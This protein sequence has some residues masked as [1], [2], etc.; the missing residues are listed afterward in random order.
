[1]ERHRVYT[2]IQRHA[3][4]TQHKGHIHM[5]H[6][7]HLCPSHDPSLCPSHDLLLFPN[8]VTHMGWH[9]QGLSNRRS[10]LLPYR[11]WDRVLQDL[12]HLPKA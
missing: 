1:M 11:S 12:F 8:H 10:N 4:N 9:S 6:I 3:A 2:H 5:V 7:P